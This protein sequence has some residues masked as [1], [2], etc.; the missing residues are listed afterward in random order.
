MGQI[1]KVFNRYEKKFLIDEKTYA[2]LKKELDVYMNEDEYGL[3][4]IRNIYYDTLNDQLI[5]TSIEG[6]KYK[7]KFRV[8]CY[9]KPTYDIMCFLRLRKSIKDWLIKGGWLYLWK[10]LKDI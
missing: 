10:R 7:E 2:L 1:T 9:G 8:R 3:H 5:R 6:P 4:T